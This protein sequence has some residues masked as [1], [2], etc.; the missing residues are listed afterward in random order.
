MPI[1]LNLDPRQ[2]AAFAITLETGSLA[3]AA[4]QLHITLAAVSL[5]IK[6]LET[7]LGQRLL[8][9]SK[10]AQATRA[11]QT[12]L[13][14]IRR[15]SLLEAE[16]AERL[17]ND[18]QEADWQT[19]HVAVNAD[20]LA[21]WFLP[22]VQ[23][24][25]L[26]HKLLLQSVVDDQEHTLQ[27][28]QNGEVIGCVT[29]LAKPL[30]GCEAKPLGLMRY[31]C[32]ASPA[33]ARKLRALKRTSHASALLQ[34]PALCFNARDHLQEV[35]ISQHLGLQGASYPRHFLPA[36]DAYHLALLQ[37]LGWGMQADVQLKLQWPGVMEAGQLVEL[38]AD[39]Y[40]DVPLYWHHW[41]QE[42]AHAARFTQAVVAAARKHLIQP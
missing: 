13:A 2:L 41:A 42:A 25:L 29:Q 12:L 10:T 1:S 33:L 27:W 26:Q 7:Q 18:T 31:R 23:K 8:I 20:S 30:R 36:G 24:T 19:L 6:A 9:R 21:S 35:F 28:L 5:R 3:A 16:L 32:L 37:G 40:V 15:S 4:Q 22:G 17:G 34:I 14:H 39:A 38:T 11:G